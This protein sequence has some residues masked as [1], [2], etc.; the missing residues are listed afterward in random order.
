MVT[1]AKIKEMISFEEINGDTFKIRIVEAIDNGKAAFSHYMHHNTN[2]VSKYFKKDAFSYLKKSLE[3]KYPE[4]NITNLVAESA[5]Q[6]LLFEHN[7]FESAF[8]PP[9]N[10]TFKFIDLFAGIGGFRIAAQ[11]LGGECVFSSEWDEFAQKSYFNN[12]KETPFGDITKEQTK[13]FIPKG[14]DL[15]CAGFPCQPFSYA[16]LNKGFED[17]TR[18][19]LFFDIL[20]I[21][22]THKPNM[23]LLENVKGLK[24]HENGKTLKTIEASLK[25]L[26][27]NIQWKI[28]NSYDFGLPQYR[29]RWY[30][31]GFR[32]KVHFEFPEAEKRGV[33]LKAIIDKKYNSDKRL[34]LSEFEIE[35]IEYHFNSS[36]V[37]VE[38]DNSKYAANTKKGKHGVFSF[39]KADGSLRFHIGDT[40]K[41]QIQEAFYA[42]QDTYAPTIIANRVPKLWDLKRKLSVEEALKLQGFPNNYKFS[43]S[44]NQAYKQLGNSVAVPVIRAVLNQ[45]LKSIEK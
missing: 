11:E 24:S 29:E 23:F 33:K 20:E 38:H 5:M 7:K 31:V 22:K 26:G 15:L 32:D 40:A 27:Y 36:Q 34:Q 3:Y 42:C 12:F 10:P 4:N 8:P 39:Q 43:V 44:D 30:C 45:M 21:L 41:T 19:T 2:G 37:R 1:K 16:G 35:R 28:L 6:Q 17:A 9:K 14:F 13:K 25:N 18:G